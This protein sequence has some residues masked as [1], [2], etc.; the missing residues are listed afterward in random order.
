[1][2]LDELRHE[3]TDIRDGRRH[4]SHCGTAVALPPGWRVPYDACPCYAESTG[5]VDVDLDAEDLHISWTEGC[6][7]HY[8]TTTRD[9]VVP[10]ALIRAL[11]AR[12]EEP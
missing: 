5:G 7:D 10:T 1:M 11:L 6:D 12:L 8:G 9:V 2:R 4:C 3:A